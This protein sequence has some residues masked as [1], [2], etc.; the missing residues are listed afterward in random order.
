M[1]PQGIGWTEVASCCLHHL[2]AA[3]VGKVIYRLT[4]MALVLSGQNCVHAGIAGQG[5]PGHPVR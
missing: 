5:P 1:T 4:L 3:R 2:A